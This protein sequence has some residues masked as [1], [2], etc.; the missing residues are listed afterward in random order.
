MQAVLEGVRHGE[1]SIPLSTEVQRKIKHL[2]EE[3]AQLRKELRRFIQNPSS[4]FLL[5]DEE[6]EDRLNSYIRLLVKARTL[7]ELNEVSAT[8]LATRTFCQYQRWN[9]HLVEG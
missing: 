3:K 9:L 4:Q 5:I 8:T 1:R 6:D 7:M 2:T